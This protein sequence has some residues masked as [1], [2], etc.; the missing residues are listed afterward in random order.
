MPQS[1]KTL[2]GG[3]LVILSWAWLAGIS[4]AE[5]ETGTGRLLKMYQGCVFDSVAAQIA[6][7]N[8]DPSAISE[9][10]FQACRTEEQAI[11]AQATAGGVGSTQANQAMIE[12]R[13]S[14]KQRVRKIIAD[15]TARALR[16]TVQQQVTPPPQNPPPRGLD[17]GSSYQRYDGATVYTNCR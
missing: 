12:L 1:K 11:L 17:C 8:L 2:A 3:M 14:M 5:P 16:P 6:K 4:R 10:A 7:G 13:L 15:A 9:L